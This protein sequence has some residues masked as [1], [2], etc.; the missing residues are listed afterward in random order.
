MQNAKGLPVQFENTDLIDH[1]SQ[2]CKPCN[3]QKFNLKNTYVPT[4][5]YIC[6]YICIYTY[7]YIYYV[8]IHICMCIHTY[9]HLH[10]SSHSGPQ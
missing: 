3:W 9:T 6:I 5:I 4:Y 7:I 8:Y 1:S 2:S 10:L